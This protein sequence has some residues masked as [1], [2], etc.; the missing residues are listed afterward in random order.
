MK[1]IFCPK[2]RLWQLLLYM[3]LISFGF[4]AILAIDNYRG[5]KDLQ[6]IKCTDSNKVVRSTLK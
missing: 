6:S 1:K 3:S 2:S 4:F 5:R